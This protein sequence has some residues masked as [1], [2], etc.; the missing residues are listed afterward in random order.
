M[1]ADVE[2]LLRTATSEPEL[3]RLLQR[4]CEPC[5]PVVRT[6]VLA[7]GDAPAQLM[8]VVQMADRPAAD[9]VADR[10][11]I[12]VF[13]SHMAVFKYEAPAGFAC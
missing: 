1:H 8:C 3:Q 6:D 4:L 9:R 7:S 2:K 5:G 12:N 10:F 11:G 13:G